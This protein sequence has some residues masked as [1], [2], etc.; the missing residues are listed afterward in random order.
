MQSEILR[1]DN[2]ITQISNTNRII[3]KGNIR[4][5]TPITYKKVNKPVLAI[6]SPVFLESVLSQ[7]SACLNCFFYL[8]YCIKGFI[9]CQSSSTHVQWVGRLI[10]WAILSGNTGYAF[11]GLFRE[12]CQT[13][14]VVRRTCTYIWSNWG[15]INDIL[16]FFYRLKLPIQNCFT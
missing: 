10:E 4:K 2:S 13:L 14:N 11:K 5:K 3:Y 15:F 16:P 1:H 7:V 12:I 9:Q 6:K 8:I